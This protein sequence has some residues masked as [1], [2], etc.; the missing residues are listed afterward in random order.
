MSCTVRSSA[1]GAA[2]ALALTLLALPARA[3]DWPQ[4][5]LGPTRTRLSAE[6]SGPSFGQRGWSFGLPMGAQRDAVYRALIASPAVQDGF[7][8]LGTSDGQVRAIEE[9]SGTSLWSVSVGAALRASPALHEG[10][11]YVAALDGRLRA[12]RLDTG[13]EMWQRDLGGIPY[14]SPLVADGG[15]FIAVGSPSPRVLRL[16]PGTGA[17]IWSTS[18]AA[19]QQPSETSVAVANG[20]VIVGEMQGRYHSFDATSGAKQWTFETAGAVNLSS[21]LVQDGRVYMLPGGDDKRMFAVD[22]L[23][24]VPIAG[25]P[26]EI[27]VPVDAAPGTRLHQDRVISSAAGTSDRLMFDMRVD[28]ALDTAAQGVANRWLIREYTVAVDLT[29]A[30]VAWMLANGRRLT[31]D[32]NLIPTLGMCPTPALFHGSHGEVLAASASTLDPRIAVIDV[33]AGV[34]RWSAPL[35]GPTRGSPVFANGQLVVATDAGTLHAFASSSNLPPGV[36]TGGFL[37]SSGSTVDAQSIVLGWAAPSDPDGDTLTYQV[38]YDNDGEILHTWQKE[39]TTTSTTA[40]LQLP[41]GDYVFSVR[42]RDPSGAWSPW[43][44]PNAFR[45]VAMPAVSVDGVPVPGLASALQTAHAGQTIGLGVGTYTLSGTLHLPSGV[46]LIGAG[47]HLTRIDAAGAAIGI[48]VDGG[49]AARA[50]IRGLKIEGAAIGVAVSHTKAVELRNII[51]RDNRDAGL[52]VSASSEAQLI[53]G[54]VTHNGV[55]VRAFGPTQLRNTI[56]TDNEHGLAAGQAGVLTTRYCDLF[57]N[58]ADLDNVTPGAGDLT[59]AVQFQR[60]DEGDLR[61]DG[62]QA[63]TDRGDPQDPFDQEPQPNGGRVNLGAFG[64]T[65][66]AELSAVEPSSAVATPPP[67]AS[68]VA[69]TSGNSAPRADGGGCEVGGR[70][71]RTTNFLL[72]LLAAGAMVVQRRAG[73]RR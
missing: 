35:S 4:L 5:G 11:T 56:I 68:P 40:A 25:W 33:A 26:I 30:R 47:P 21:P 17:T 55:G 19:L 24:G 7:I 67:P 69:P 9:A 61:L 59:V 1:G 23:T 64:N 32:P 36:S 16:D 52:D 31:G 45:A 13:A 57:A 38:R 42:S 46:S 44:P 12:L 71:P 8:V 53:N 58:R 70:P 66:S 43:S 62:P 22:L 3:D 39:L 48:A 2:L 29:A 49:G 60:A 10:W 41:A 50:E 14:S 28:E 6:I 34:E 15:L 20:H 54:T 65:A 37:P 73:R 27:A 18:E 51:L 63:T 72:A